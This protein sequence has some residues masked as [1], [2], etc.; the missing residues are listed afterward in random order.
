MTGLRSLTLVLLATCG[1]GLAAAAG[2]EAFDG[3]A[4]LACDLVH[5]AQCDAAAA[6]R[7]V[8]LAQIDLPP[9]FHVDFEGRRLSS[10]DE[11]RTSPIAVVQMLEAALLLQG[12]QNGRG[13]TMLIDR[14]TGHL[15]VS[16]ADIEGAFVLSGAC[17]GR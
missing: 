6:C 12:H 7:E 9:E 17:T 13:W 11:A 4:P 16:V 3:S 1:A 14:V 5:A 10:P 8:T 2:A 15:S